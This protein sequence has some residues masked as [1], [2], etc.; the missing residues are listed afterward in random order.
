M[1]THKLETDLDCATTLA[2]GNDTPRPRAE[3]VDAAAGEAVLDDDTALAYLRDLDHVDDTGL[4][5]VEVP[6]EPIDDDCPLCQALRGQPSMT[7]VMPDEEALEPLTWVTSGPPPPP[8]PTNSH[9]RR[10]ARERRRRR[11]HA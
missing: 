11:L 2:V 3:E 10:R 4:R 9:A 7:W 1:R 5:F 8:P 6:F